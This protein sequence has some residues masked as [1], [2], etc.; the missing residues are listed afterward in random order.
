MV[1]RLWRHVDFA[2]RASD[3]SAR[4]KAQRIGFPRFNRPLKGQSSVG[5]VWPSPRRSRLENFRGHGEFECRNF[6]SVTPGGPSGYSI[7]A[8]TRPCIFIHGRV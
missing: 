4:G 1:S 5:Y 6:R 3:E 7:G 2:H 8:Q